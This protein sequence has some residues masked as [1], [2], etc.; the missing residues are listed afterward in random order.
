MGT[1]RRLANLQGSKT[2]SGT[3]LKEGCQSNLQRK[4]G[5]RSLSGT[6]LGGGIQDSRNSICKGQGVGKNSFKEL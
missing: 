5:V 2:G 6:P 3:D 4:R 1:V